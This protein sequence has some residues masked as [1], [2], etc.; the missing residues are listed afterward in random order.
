MTMDERTRELL[1]RMEGDLCESHI[2]RMRDTRMWLR[3]VHRTLRELRA[4]MESVAPEGPMRF[5]GATISHECCG[6]CKTGTA[7]DLC[8]YPN[9]LDVFQE[10]I[11][12]DDADN[13]SGQ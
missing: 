2:A 9:M 8:G 5:P 13:T 7:S 3:A 1:D 10:F 12:H 6:H 4:H 11:P